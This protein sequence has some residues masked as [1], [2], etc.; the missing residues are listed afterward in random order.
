MASALRLMKSMELDSPVKGVGALVLDTGVGFG[1]SVGIGEVYHRYGDKWAGKNVARLTAGVGKGL[2]VLLSVLSGG[3]PTFA[4][5][6]ANSVGQA[7]VNAIGLELG[8]RHARKATGKKAV[9]VPSDT[10][11]KKLAGA[12]DVSLMGA[13]GRA[14]AGRAMSWDQ[15]EELATGR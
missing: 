9:L 8:L 6:L 4:S 12:S 1:A 5:H 15:V 11:V 14:A 3:H 13:L 7:G 2:S 10:D